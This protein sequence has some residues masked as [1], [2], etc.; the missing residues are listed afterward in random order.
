VIEAGKY[1]AEGRAL[2]YFTE[3]TKPLSSPPIKAFSGG[4]FAYPE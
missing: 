4:Q 1:I 3:Q 2:P